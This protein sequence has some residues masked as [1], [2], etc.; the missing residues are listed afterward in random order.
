MFV[1]VQRMMNSSIF[2]TAV[3]IKKCLKMNESNGFSHIRDFVGAKE[4]CLFGLL[5]DSFGVY[6]LQRS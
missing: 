2:Q 6:D 5:N 1:D 3:N 4:G